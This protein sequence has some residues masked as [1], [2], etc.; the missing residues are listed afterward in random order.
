MQASKGDLDTL[1]HVLRKAS[2][3]DKE[4]KKAVDSICT[5]LCRGPSYQDLDEWLSYYG[6]KYILPHVLDAL[7]NCHVKFSHVIELGAGTGWLGQEIAATYRVDCALVDKRYPIEKMDNVWDRTYSRP[8]GHSTTW[9]HLDLE[10]DDGLKALTNTLRPGDLLIMSE[11]LHCLD[12]PE[13]VVASL[14]HYPWVVV[15][16]DA[17]D[18]IYGQSYIE[19]L[20]KYGATAY[21]DLYRNIAVG[22][23]RKLIR[24]IHPYIGWVLEARE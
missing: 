18:P 14:V 16:Y 5:H 4:T 11:F 21:P 13:S 12:D 22:R 2:L 9:S 7:A 10:T 20:A 8:D 6:K 15:E 17:A 19:Q 1:Y 23:S 3:S 24:N